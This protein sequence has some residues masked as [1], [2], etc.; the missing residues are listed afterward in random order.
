MLRVDYRV[1]SVELVKYLKELGVPVEVANL[2]FG[3][4][5][6]L[7]NG[8]GGPVGV[9]IERKTLGDFVSSVWT[10]RLHSHQIPGLVS[11]YHHVWIV[12]EGM[13]RPDSS[14]GILQVPMGKSW[15]PFVPKGSSKPIMY[16]ELE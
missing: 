10:G 5:E 13:W 7:G 14:T 12:L 1:G 6:F 8:S 4:M 16:R 11:R 2:A 15:I 9:G 3:D